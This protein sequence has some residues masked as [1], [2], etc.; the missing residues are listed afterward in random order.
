MPTTYA[1]I[2]GYKSVVSVLIIFNYVVMFIL[3]VEC[4]STSEYLCYW[5]NNNLKIIDN[6][7]NNEMSAP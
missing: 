7:K 3:L 4:K 1:H 2:Y 6:F 5:Y